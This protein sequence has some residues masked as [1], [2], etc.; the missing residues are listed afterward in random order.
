MRERIKKHDPR[1]WTNYQQEARNYKIADC[2]KLK[3]IKN[4]VAYF[5]LRS[6]LNRK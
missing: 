6:R 5:A 3:K 4:Q 2:W 1:I